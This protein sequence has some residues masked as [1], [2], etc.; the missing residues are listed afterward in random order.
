MQW[1]V[2]FEQA[3]QGRR[4]AEGI[5]DPTSMWSPKGL[6]QA[7]L[8]STSGSSDA[9]LRITDQ[10]IA[11][12]AAARQGAAVSLWMMVRVPRPAGGRSAR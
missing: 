2:A 8:L 7:I 4:T 12:A 1:D 3:E 11:D 6:W 10:G 9:A 5:A